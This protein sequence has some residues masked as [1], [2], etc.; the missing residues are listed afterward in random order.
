MSHRRLCVCVCVELGMRVET[1]T[2]Y[3]RRNCGSQLLVLSIAGPPDSVC[4]TSV[5]LLLLDQ[6]NIIFVYLS[7]RKKKCVGPP[8]NFSKDS[9]SCCRYCKR[10][11]AS[12]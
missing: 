5:N 8:R 7:A 9:M 1:A 10:A 12:A 11:D 4:M 2:P 6:N 3:L